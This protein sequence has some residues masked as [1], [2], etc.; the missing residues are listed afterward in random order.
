MTKSDAIYWL[1]DMAERSRQ[2]YMPNYTE[3]LDMAIEALSEPSE[4]DTCK[5]KD[6]PWDFIKCDTCT[7]GNSNY[8]PSKV[9][10]RKE[11]E[12]REPDKCE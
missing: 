11:R 2:K 7:V 6:K 3:A 8:E 4:C 5:Y 10:F 9:D 1:K 12:R